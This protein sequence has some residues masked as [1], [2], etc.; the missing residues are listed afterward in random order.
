MIIDCST[1]VDVIQLFANV[2]SPLS[3]D[4]VKA[5]YDTDAELVQEGLD[6]SFVVMAGQC[7][8]CNYKSIDICPS[9]CD[10]DNLE[11]DNCGNMAVQERE[12]LEWEE[13]YE[14]NN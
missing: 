5:L 6:R 8:V 2:G 3:F 12:P 7:R 11:C 13:G 14:D 1:K 10:I 4:S 9:I